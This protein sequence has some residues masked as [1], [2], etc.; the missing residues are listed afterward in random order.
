MTQKELAE[1]LEMSSS[2][3]DMWEAG[4]RELELSKIIKIAELFEITLDNLILQQLKP[5]SPFYVLNIKYLREKNKM[6]QEDM[7]NLLGF[8]SQ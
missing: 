6:A 1:K 2:V 4:I 7:A 8:K 5:P 3:V